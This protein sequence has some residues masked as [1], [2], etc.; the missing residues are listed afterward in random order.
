MAGWRRLATCFCAAWRSRRTPPPGAI[1]SGLGQLGDAEQSAQAGR[2]ADQLMNTRLGAITGS[3]ICAGSIRRPSPGRVR[4]ATGLFRR[5]PHRPRPAAAGEKACGPVAL[6]AGVETVGKRKKRIVVD[7]SIGQA[8]CCARQGV[9]NDA[10][11]VFSSVVRMGRRF[12]D[13]RLRSLVRLGATVC[14]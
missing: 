10:T 2:R 14:S 12:G 11:A 7:R 6:E 8:I 5:P 4:R 9:S 13:R 1:C 3:R